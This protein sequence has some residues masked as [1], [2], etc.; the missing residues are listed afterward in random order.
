MKNKFILAIAI[1]F[2]VAGLVAFDVYRNSPMI[3]KPELFKN[4]N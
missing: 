1:V 2:C 4:K 3:Q